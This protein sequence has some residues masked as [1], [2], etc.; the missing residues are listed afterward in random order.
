MTVMNK[1]FSR[2][3]NPPRPR[4]PNVGNSSN[5]KIPHNSTRKSGEQR[6]KY[7]WEKVGLINESTCSTCYIEIGIVT[8][9]AH[10]YFTVK[11]KHC[12]NRRW[13]LKQREPGNSGGNLCVVRKNPHRITGSGKK[14]QVE[15][16]NS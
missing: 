9:K 4:V 12:S 7:Q 5:R 11:N 1:G 15:G 16:K 6:L 2:K 14:A 3:T 8:C 10:F 13:Y